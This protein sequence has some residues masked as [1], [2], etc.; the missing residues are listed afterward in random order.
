MAVIYFYTKISPHVAGS[1]EH[2]N[3]PSVSIKSSR[4]LDWRSNYYLLKKESEYELYI[5]QNCR[6]ALKT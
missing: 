4:C 5:V 2:S 6:N 3:K 1:C